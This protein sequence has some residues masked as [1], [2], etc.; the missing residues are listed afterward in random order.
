MADDAYEWLV[1]AVI[2]VI[3]LYVIAVMVGSFIQQSGLFGELLF[4]GGVL[5]AIV[6]GAKKIFD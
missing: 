2:V 1:A 3:G 5:T 4:G 6:V